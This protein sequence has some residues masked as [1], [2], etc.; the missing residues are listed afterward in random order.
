MPS[1]L[2][3]CTANLCRSPM[4]MAILR[5]KVGHSCDEWRIESAGTWA[6]K[7]V[8]ANPK[9]QQIITEFGMDISDHRSQIVSPELLKS[10]N[11]ILTMEPGH[12]EALQIEFPEVS[13]RIYLLSEM[14]GLNFMITDPVGGEIEEYR[15]TAREIERII[16]DG[17]EKITRLANA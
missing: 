17:F 7:G 5:S 13:G 11:L 2:F 12:K 15:A 8:R 14:I 3:V 10:F 4:A 6:A 16:S 1:V 9:T